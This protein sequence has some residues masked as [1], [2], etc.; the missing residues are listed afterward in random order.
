MFC[1]E[2]NMP[3]CKQYNE[4]MTCTKYFDGCNTC[5]IENGKATCTETFCDKLQ[6]PR[7]LDEKTQVDPNL[8]PALPTEIKK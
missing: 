1:E 2:P 4:S 5:T 3:Q 7:C 8:K 6:E